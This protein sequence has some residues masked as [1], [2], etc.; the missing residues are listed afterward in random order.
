MKVDCFWHATLCSL[1]SLSQVARR[2]TPEERSL[3]NLPLKTSDLTYSV[4]FF[5]FIVAIP[6]AVNVMMGGQPP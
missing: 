6:T 4:I 3:H 2:R 5:I 1:V